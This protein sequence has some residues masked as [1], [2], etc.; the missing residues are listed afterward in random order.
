LFALSAETHDG[1]LEAGCF[2]VSML[3]EEQHALARHFSRKAGERGKYDG[4][5]HRSAT[6]GSPILDGALAWADCEL[7]AHHAGGDHTIFVGEVVAGGTRELE[8]LIYFR[9]RF[10]YP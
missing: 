7:R 5:P 3:A 9:G 2:S 8:P 10:G 4:V 6:T 1:I